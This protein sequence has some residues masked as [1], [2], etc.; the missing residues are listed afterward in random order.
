[1]KKTIILLSIL[2]SQSVLLGQYKPM[3]ESGKV[4][5][6]HFDFTTIGGLSDSISMN[7]ADSLINGI[8]YYK[9]E[10]VLLPGNWFN[11]DVI[12]N[13]ILARE[14]T[15]I[16]KVWIFVDSIEYLWYDYS[17]MTGDTVTV[18]ANNKVAASLCDSL[19]SY[20]VTQ[21]DTFIDLEGNPRKEIHLQQVSQGVHWSCINY[22]PIVWVEGLGSKHGINMIAS[23]GVFPN[24]LCIWKSS[25]QLYQG[26]AYGDTCWVGSTIGVETFE[27]ASF[28][29]F[30]NPAIDEV[31]VRSKTHPIQSVKLYDLRGN[32]LLH[33]QNNTNDEEVTL[34]I[35]GFASGVYVLRIESTSGGIST[36]KL[37][38][39]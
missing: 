8:T 34:N 31:V 17:I 19:Q 15:T 24:T 11:I 5:T 29:I 18:F 30:P 32:V 35:N 23:Q 10:G 33:Q 9:L 4:W 25:T 36:K 37:K 27:K 12:G 1:M 28:D 38:I 39:Q 20:I 21:V 22:M 13:P 26:I 16:G 6:Q 2:F 14:D 7:G 3:L